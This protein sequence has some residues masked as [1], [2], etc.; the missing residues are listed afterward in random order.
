MIISLLNHKASIKWKMNEVMDL[1]GQDTPQ[2]FD[3][4]AIVNMDERDP[5]ESK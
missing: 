5:T 3:C 4:A 1:L 2:V